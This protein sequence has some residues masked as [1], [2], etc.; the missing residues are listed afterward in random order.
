MNRLI[1]S[2]VEG[3]CCVFK[4]SFEFKSLFAST[5][6]NSRASFFQVVIISAYVLLKFLTRSIKMYTVTVG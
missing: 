1:L 2:Q 4:N 3:K 6:Q 5:I